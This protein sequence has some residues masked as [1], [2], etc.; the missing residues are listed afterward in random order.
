[1]DS[2]GRL[3][4]N[5]KGFTKMKK[6][7]KNIGKVMFVNNINENSFKVIFPGINRLKHQNQSN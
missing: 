7:F 4:K 2:Q 5:E 3:L 1:M 6:L